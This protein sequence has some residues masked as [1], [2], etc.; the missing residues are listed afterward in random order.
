M[1]FQIDLGT[2]LTAPISSIETEYN[3]W[4]G[5]IH[6]GG[7]KVIKTTRDLCPAGTFLIAYQN[8]RFVAG[9]EIYYEAAQLRLDSPF[10]VKDSLVLSDENMDM[11]IF[12]GG[13]Y[14]RY[15]FEVSNPNIM[16]YLGTT[17]GIAYTTIGFEQGDVDNLQIGLGFIIGTLFMVHPNLGLGVSARYDHYYPLTNGMLNFDTKTGARVEMDM[18]YSMGEIGTFFNM[19][20]MF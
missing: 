18:K 11:V 2:S 5:A 17:L 7:K 4:A 6:K 12:R 9:G 19:A 14:F 15:Y 1:L 13:P 3:Y 16:P 10:Y 20:L 8:S